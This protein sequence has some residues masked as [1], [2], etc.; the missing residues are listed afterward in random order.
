MTVERSKRRSLLALTFIAKSTSKNL[1]I[2]LLPF[3]WFINY[4]LCFFVTYSLFI[5]DFLRIFLIDFIIASS[6]CWLIPSR[7]SRL[8]VARRGRHGSA[9]CDGK[10]WWCPAH[11]A[12]WRRL[13]TSQ[14][15]DN[16]RCNACARDRGWILRPFTKFEM[17]ANCLMS[18]RMRIMGMD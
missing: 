12:T 6:C 13:R 5:W 16:F 17:T 4:S 8:H 1:L 9:R 7:L 2:R 10:G 14:L 3:S 18:Y 15:L 11:R